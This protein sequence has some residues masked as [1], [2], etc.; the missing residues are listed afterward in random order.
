MNNSLTIQTSNPCFSRLL[1]LPSMTKKEGKL[2]AKVAETILTL[3]GFD[4]SIVH[5][6]KGIKK[7]LRRDINSEFIASP[8]FNNLDWSQLTEYLKT[9][10]G[11]REVIRNVLAMLIVAENM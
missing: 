1:N 7:Y 4:K 5:T 2:A 6:A 8:K 11:Q 10:K 3:A 9:N